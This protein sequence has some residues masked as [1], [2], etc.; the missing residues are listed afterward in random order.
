MVSLHDLLLESSALDADV[1]YAGHHCSRSNSARDYPGGCFHFIR[2]G[3]AEL[4]VPGQPSVLIEQPSLVF[5]A[6]A[7]AH[8]VR[9]VDDEGIEMVCAVAA[10]DKAFTRAVDLAFPDYLIVP[11]CRFAAISQVL[12]AFFAEAQSRSPGSKTLANRLCTVVLT[13]LTH[14]MLERNDPAA[15]LL[16]AAT[17]PRIAAAV[18]AIHDRFD[19]ELDLETLAS[20]AGMSRSRFVQRF[21]ELVGKSPHHYLLNYRIARAKRL[22]EAGLPV[23][24][25]ASRVGYRTA[26]AFIQKFK[27]VAGVTP[28]AWV[29]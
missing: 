21:V 5:F 20:L 7:R 11:L 29:Q 13:Y 17:D 6:N 22:L 10:Y 3:S 14:S 28:G 16:G 12:E 15:G 27:Q 24:V 23:K 1:I 4:V 26:S 19:H 8:A 18:S 2:S 25:V 9:A